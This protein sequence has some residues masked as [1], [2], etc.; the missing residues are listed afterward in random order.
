VARLPRIN[1]SIEVNK[2]SNVVKTAIK[3]IVSAG[4]SLRGAL[5]DQ[6]P[7]IYRE[8]IAPKVKDD[9]VS[10]ADWEPIR[11][12]LTEYVRAPHVRR[13]ALCNRVR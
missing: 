1:Q 10:A 11:K 3:K 5:S 6:A 7:V 2:M 12:I 9:K 8:L 4:E 13:Y